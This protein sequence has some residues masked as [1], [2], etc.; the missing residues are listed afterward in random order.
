MLLATNSRAEEDVR[1]F[2]LADIFVVSREVLL[3]CYFPEFNDSDFDEANSV[4]WE[5]MRLS[6]FMGNFWSCKLL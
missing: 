3:V 4:F 2:N 1:D 6:R 5:L